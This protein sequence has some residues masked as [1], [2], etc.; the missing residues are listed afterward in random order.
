MLTTCCFVLASL[1]CGRIAQAEDVT[2][3]FAL[4]ETWGTGYAHGRATALAPTTNIGLAAIIPVGLGW[5]W[6][7]EVGMATPNTISHPMPRILSGP[8]FKLGNRTM[9]AIAGSFQVD[10]GYWKNATYLVGLAGAL[11]FAILKEISVGISVGAAK[12][13]AQDGA[14]C[15]TYQPRIFFVLPW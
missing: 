11:Q 7:N 6:Y 12:V 2:W 5:G 3:K 14:W 15:V 8:G 1:A 9:F 4:G 13:L 10:P